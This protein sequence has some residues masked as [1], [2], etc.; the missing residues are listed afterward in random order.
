MGNIVCTRPGIMMIEI[1]ETED[2]GL[3]NTNIT[4]DINQRK[5]PVPTD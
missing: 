3:L 1:I 4:L 5:P 2:T